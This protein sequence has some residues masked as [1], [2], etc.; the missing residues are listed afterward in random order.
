MLDVPITQALSRYLDLQTARMKLTATNMANQNTVGYA[1]RTVTW[2][3]GDTVSLSGTVPAEAP[4]AT[5]TAQRSAV[6]DGALIG[7]AASSASAT[8]VKSALNDLQSIFA[9]GSSGNEGSGINAAMSGFFA[10]MQSVA[11][12]P[13]ST[14]EPSGASKAPAWA[15]T[16]R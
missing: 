9:I 10:A 7:T 14:S 2:T 6:L 11:A 8:V 4:V 12:D 16:A 1:R 3:S 13:S 5:V 15:S